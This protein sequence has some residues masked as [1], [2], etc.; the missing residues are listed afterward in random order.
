MKSKDEK[1]FWPIISAIFFGNFL[2][3]MNTSTVNVAVPAFMAEFS[4]ELSMAQWTITGFMLAAGAAAPSAGWFGTRFGYKKVYISVLGGFFVF[5]VLCIFAPTIESLIFFR[6]MQGICSGILMPSTMT[7]VYQTIEKKRQAYALSLWSLSAGL[8]PAIGP[9]LAGF[10]IDLFDWKAMFCLNLPIAAI[11]MAAAM[12]FLPDTE[13][14]A[15]TPFDFPGFLFSFI[16]SMLLLITFSEGGSWGWLYSKTLMTAGFAILFLAL[17]VRRELRVEFPLLNFSVLSHR[18]FVYSLLL[19]AV[20][21]TGLYVGAFLLPIFLQTGLQL[22]AFETGLIMM[23]SALMMVLFTPVSG[24]LYHKTG[25]VPLIVAGI[26]LMMVGTY[27]LG[28]LSIESTTVYIIIWTSVR[29]IGIALCNMPITNAG[30]S[31]VPLEIAGYASAMNNWVRQ[32]SASFSIAFFSTLLAYQISV[33]VQEG[34]SMPAAASFAVGDAFFYSLI[35]LMMALSLSV[36]LQKDKR[37]GM[38][39]NNERTAS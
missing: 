7:L 18:K 33:H 3:V 34:N 37:S 23:P 9:V 15:K 31:A 21:S 12:K 24:K 14:G 4:A 11:A 1:A 6:M 19:K 35:P 26:F 25:P 16:G 5:S 36:L 32:C 22:D 27:M 8:A 20:L 29:Y 28:S 13:A 17:F 38:E 39:K 2:A 30:M 10:L